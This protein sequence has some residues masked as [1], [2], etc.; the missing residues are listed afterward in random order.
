MNRLTCCHRG[1]NT[2]VFW[3]DVW[4]FD[5]LGEGIDISTY[6]RETFDDVA[7]LVR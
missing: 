3:A 5:E 1:G 6:A 2:H 4:W 7:S